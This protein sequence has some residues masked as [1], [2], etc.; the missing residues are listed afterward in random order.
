VKAT[1]LMPVTYSRTFNWQYC[2]PAE[3]NNRTTTSNTPT[4]S[5]CRL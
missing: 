5:L 4:N 1:S 3:I 2:L